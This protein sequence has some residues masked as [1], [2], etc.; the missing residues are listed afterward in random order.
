MIIGTLNGSRDLYDPWTGFTQFTLLDEK[1]PDGYTVVRGEI[2]EE[3]S[4]HPGQIIILWPDLWK[5][6]GK[7]AKLNQKQKWTEEKIHLENASKL[8]G[9]Y[10]IDPRIRN[11][12]HPS[13]TQVIR[14]WKHQWLL[15]CLAKL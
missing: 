1:A 5:S 9:I 7:H 13:K 6:M 14:S 3:S 12:K 4:L 2:D 15:L 10:F 8:R 11:S